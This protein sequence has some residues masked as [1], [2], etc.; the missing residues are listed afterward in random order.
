M[1]LRWTQARRPVRFTGGLGRVAGLVDRGEVVQVVAATVRDGD[2]VVDLVGAGAFADV[3][4]PVVAVQDVLAD[5]VPPSG[6]R[7]GAPF[8]LLVWYAHVSPG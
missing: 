6:Q 8:M 5:P 2:D 1:F 7:L 4:A 3:A